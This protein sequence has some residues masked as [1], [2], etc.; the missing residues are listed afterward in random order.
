MLVGISLLFMAFTK[1]PEIP[2][3]I[4]HYLNTHFG[5]K[6]VVEYKAKWKAAKSKH[7][8]YLIDKTKLEFDGDLN[9][10]EVKSKTGIPYSTVPQNVLSYIQQNYPN[11]KLKKWEKETTKQEVKLIDGPELE[12]DLNGNF[13]RIDD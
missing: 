13:L 10:V 7:K 5:N 9:I 12:F 11:S 6:E 2:K 1:S 3:E 4:Q 8:V